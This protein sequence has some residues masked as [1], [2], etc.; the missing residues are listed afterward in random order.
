MQAALLQQHVACSSPVLSCALPGCS[1][2]ALGL[3]PACG[4]TAAAPAVL[5]VA[6]LHLSSRAQPQVQGLLS[7][8]RLHHVNIAQSA[9]GVP[10]ELD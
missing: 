9:K 7:I 10:M 2:L 3:L 6:W 1:A 5:H 4:S 8:P